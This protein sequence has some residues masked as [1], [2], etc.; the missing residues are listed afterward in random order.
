[1]LESGELLLG[2]GSGAT[3]TFTPLATALWIALRQHDG[4]LGD[5]A[6]ALSLLWNADC[7]LIH[8]ELEMWVDELQAAGLIRMEP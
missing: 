1:M 2:L 6:D 3:Y 7:V 8:A 4:N 5:A